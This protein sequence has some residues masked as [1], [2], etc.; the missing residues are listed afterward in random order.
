M[1]IYRK[2]PIEIEARQFNF[3]DREGVDEI[4]KWIR[5]GGG[6]VQ[7][8]SGPKGVK[9]A[10][11]HTLEGPQWITDGDWIIKGVANEFCT[12]KNHVF[13]ESYELVVEE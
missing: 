10:A 1:G 6:A 2:R 3:N 7:L 11:I 4:L 13:E 9:T 5:N 8:N 12:C